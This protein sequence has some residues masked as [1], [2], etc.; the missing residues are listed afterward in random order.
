MAGRAPLTPS[1]A[2]L[3]FLAV[4]NPD[5]TTHEHNNVHIS[6]ACLCIVAL[7]QVHAISHKLT[8]AATT[9]H[10]THFCSL[11]PHLRKSITRCPLRKTS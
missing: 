5:M 3:R 11:C 9:F 10:P 6:R 1:L 4:R 8:R 2:V 7:A